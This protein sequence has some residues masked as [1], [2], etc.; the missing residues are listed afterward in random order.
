MKG[1][2]SF[3]LRIDESQYKGIEALALAK[4]QSVN[5]YIAESLAPIKTQSS[6][7]FSVAGVSLSLMNLQSHFKNSI[8]GVVLFGSQATGDAHQDSDIDLL[9]VLKSTLEIE[10]DLYRIWDANFKEL[11]KISP[12]FSHFPEAPEKASSLWL[13]VALHGIVLW[14]QNFTVNHAL[15]ELRRY[16]YDNKLERKTAHGQGYWLKKLGAQNAK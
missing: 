12:Q 6:E 1:K 5:S 9:L 8:L 2:H 4:R 14:E 13:E 10:R 15:Q 16:I 11:N 7:I 3:L